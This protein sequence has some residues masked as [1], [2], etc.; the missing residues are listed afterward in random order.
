MAADPKDA[1]RA[2][3]LTDEERRQV[4]TPRIALGTRTT[5]TA[6]ERLVAVVRN[7]MEPAHGILVQEVIT[8]P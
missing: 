3:R 8:T 7:E 2:R 1:G 6:L 4:D 5:S